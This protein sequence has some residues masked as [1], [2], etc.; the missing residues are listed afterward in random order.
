MSDLLEEMAVLNSIQLKDVFTADLLDINIIEVNWSLGLR[1]V[2]KHHLVQLK[3]TIRKLGK[4]QRMLLYVNTLDFMD[5]NE[6][7]RV[8]S[9]T[10]EAQEYSLANAVLID[11]LGKK[12]MYNF[13]LKFHTPIVPSRAFSTKEQAIDWL[14]SMK[15][16][17]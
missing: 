1:E 5:F 6:E 3:E 13:Y 2:T 14:L 17:K 11:S 12:I 10:A 8:Y 4:G 9:V 15:N 16:E 7:S